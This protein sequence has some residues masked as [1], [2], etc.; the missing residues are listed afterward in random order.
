MAKSQAK[1]TA[2]STVKEF[3]NDCERHLKYSVV[4]DKFTKADH[5]EYYSLSLAVRDRIIDRW[6][7]TQTILPENSKRVY[8]LS[9]EFLLGRMLENNVINLGIEEEVR[10]ACKQLGVDYDDLREVGEDHGLGN[11]GLGRLAACFLDSLASL[12]YPAVGYGI[13]YEYGIFRQEIKDGF[14]VEEPD[15]WLAKGNPW[16]IACPNLSVVIRFGGRIIKPEGE[17]SDAFKWVDTNEILA[18][19]YDTPVVGFEN[20]CVNTLR[21][22]SARATHDFDLQEFNDGDYFAAVQDKNA[23]EKITKVLYPN[24][25]NYEGKALRFKQQYF[26]V[27]ASVQDIVK[28]YKRS[29]ENFDSFTDKVAIQ[30]M[31]LTPH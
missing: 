31:I 5:D 19:P 18:V 12:S 27:S 20:D 23:A 30:R 7:S 22:W 9:L 4:K 29:H 1:S 10:V 14:Q 6:F 11:G 24:D 8:Y 13:R 2:Q 25:N 26:F 28:R 17:K 21:L 3:T 15:N 16:E